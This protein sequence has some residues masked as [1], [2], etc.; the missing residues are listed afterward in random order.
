MI[1]RVRNFSQIQGKV[2]SYKVRIWFIKGQIKANYTWKFLLGHSGILKPESLTASAA[3]SHIFH[4]ISGWDKN[5]PRE[6]QCL[7]ALVQTPC[8]LFT[9]DGTLSFYDVVLKPKTVLT[10]CSFDWLD[11][12]MC[13]LRAAYCLKP[14]ISTVIDRM[15]CPNHLPHSPCLPVVKVLTYTF[16]RRTQYTSCGFSLFENLTFYSF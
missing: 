9:Q 10:V 5:L 1:V 7:W 12:E 8:L 4:N 11:F 2:S 3:V 16:Y 14:V 13:S 6:P 15:F